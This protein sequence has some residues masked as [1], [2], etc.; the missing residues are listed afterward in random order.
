VNKKLKNNADCVCFVL[1]PFVLAFTHTKTTEKA[2][3]FGLSARF[4]LFYALFFIFARWV[5]SID[6]LLQTL[7]FI[8]FSRNGWW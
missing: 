8:D 5:C 1:P 4:F 6:A 7:L 3:S 2:L